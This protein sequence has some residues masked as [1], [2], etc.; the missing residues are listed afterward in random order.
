MKKVKASW[1]SQEISK[2]ATIN[3]VCKIF[4]LVDPP[5]PHLVLL[6]STKSMVPLYII[7]N[8]RNLPYFDQI[9]NDPSPSPRCWSH[10]WMVPMLG[11][12]SSGQPHPRELQVSMYKEYCYCPCSPPRSKRERGASKQL[13]TTASA[14]AVTSPFRFL[15]PSF[16]ILHFCNNDLCVFRISWCYYGGKSQRSYKSARAHFFSR[17]I[18]AIGFI[19]ES[20][21]PSLIHNTVACS[22]T[23][24]DWVSSQ[25]VES[26]WWRHATLRR[27]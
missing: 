4:G 3:D 8:P 16:S 2:W 24:N 21:I 14:A 9:S 15:Y 25:I 7:L 20:Y 10:K 22:P 6:Y 1:E 26:I 27:A 13:V 18:K 19:W 12:W 5:C 17:Y 11:W 23:R